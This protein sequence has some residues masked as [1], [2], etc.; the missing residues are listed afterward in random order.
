MRQTSTIAARQINENKV[1]FIAFWVLLSTLLYLLFPVIVIP[2]LLS[3]DIALRA[4]DLGSY[5]PFAQLSDTA[6]KVFGFEPSIISSE[7]VARFCPL[8]DLG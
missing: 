3:A 8:K 6:I 4:F 5:S 7:I 2:L 1:R